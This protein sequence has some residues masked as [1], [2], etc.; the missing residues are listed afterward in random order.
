MTSE[1]T[2]YQKA[3][4]AVQDNIDF[5]QPGGLSFAWNASIGALVV[6]PSPM[7]CDWDDHLV[8]P[9]FALN[10]D[11]LAAVFDQPPTIH[12]LTGPKPGMVFEGIIEGERG[13]VC[14]FPEPFDDEAPIATVSASA[15]Q[16]KSD[17]N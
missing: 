10:V 16:R 3:A 9:P 15:I 7:E 5:V 2:W 1:K 11:Q 6:A 14:V 12:W 17:P 8:Y 13:L 4:R